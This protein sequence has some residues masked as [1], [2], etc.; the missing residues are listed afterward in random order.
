MT[1]DEWCTK[2]LKKVMAVTINRNISDLHAALN[3]AVKWKLI[4][5]NPLNGLTPLKT[6]KNPVVQYLEK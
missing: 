2:R 4:E 1:I 3:Q 5:T 6:K